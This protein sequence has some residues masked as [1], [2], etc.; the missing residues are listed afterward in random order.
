MKALTEQQVDD[1]RRHG[2]LFPIPMLTAAEAADGMRNIERLDQLESLVSIVRAMEVDVEV[3]VPGATRPV[4]LYA[5][6]DGQPVNPAQWAPG[7][8]PFNPKFVTGPVEQGGKLVENWKSGDP[9]DPS[10]RLTGRGSADDKAGVFTILNAYA[11]LTAAGGT[12][13]ANL[14]FF[15]DSEL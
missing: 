8:E 1:Y 13:S 10:W 14:K 12:P 7:W 4:M 5:H 3:K 6:F 2:F 11:A 15:F 9:V